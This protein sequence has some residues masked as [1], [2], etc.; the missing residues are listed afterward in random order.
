MQ[1]LDVF[2]QETV[3]RF[4]TEKLKLVVRSLNKHDTFKCNPDPTAWF[5]S[6]QPVEGNDDLLED[7]LF[8]P[9]TSLDF[10]EE[11][12][13]LLNHIKLVQGCIVG[14]FC[15]MFLVQDRWKS[16]DQL[17]IECR[18]SPLLEFCALRT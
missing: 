18:G 9:D 15:V 16:T 2:L 3:P 10:S 7:D 5:L 11:I 12:E 14:Q 17:L 6:Y 8:C 1:S 4:F 13:L